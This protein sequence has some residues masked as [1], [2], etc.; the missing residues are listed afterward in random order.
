MG[1]NVVCSSCRL[2]ATGSW[3]DAAFAPPVGLRQRTA[4]LT[5]KLRIGLRS[6]QCAQLS[7]LPPDLSA[8][9]GRASSARK[10]LRQFEALPATSSSSSLPSSMPSSRFRFSDAR[11][12]SSGAL[13][14]RDGKKKR[15]SL[16]FSLANIGQF[17]LGKLLALCESKEVIVKYV[18]F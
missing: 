5:K 16:A 7:W 13:S 10:C 8:L 6:A 18:Q 4:W 14:L 17:V 2:G 11:R 9:R 12:R 15:K 1:Q 3:E